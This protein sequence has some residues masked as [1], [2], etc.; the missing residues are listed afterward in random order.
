MVGLFQLQSCSLIIFPI[1]PLSAATGTPFLQWSKMNCHTSINI[2]GKWVDKKVYRKIERYAFWWIGWFSVAGCFWKA[3]AFCNYGSGP[4][5]QP[6]KRNKVSVSCLASFIIV[7]AAGSILTPSPCSS[8][9]LSL[10]HWSIQ[11]RQRIF[12]YKYMQANL[13]W[14]LCFIEFKLQN[15]HRWIF[16]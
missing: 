6:W 1:S 12:I 5:L 7:Q 15:L 8:C 2:W 4:V 10:F 14:L 13:S 11:T 3:P 9:S 16:N